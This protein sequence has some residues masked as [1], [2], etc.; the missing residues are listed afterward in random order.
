MLYHLK[1][2]QTIRISLIKI[3]KIN[4]KNMKINRFFSNNFDNK[5][6][7][8]VS[9]ISQKISEIEDRLKSNPNSPFGRL[10]RTPKE[11]PNTSQTE[12]VRTGSDPFAPF[13]NNCNPAT[14][15]KGGPTGPEPTR[16]G[17]W[18]R[19]GRVSDF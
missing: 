4:D 8:K 17:D 11:K 14:G 5:S 7:K 9:K 19:K 15:E 18:E 13:D 6:D 3:L 1:S 2:N 16:Y 10:D 12:D